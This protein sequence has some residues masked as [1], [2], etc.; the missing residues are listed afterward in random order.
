MRIPYTHLQDGLRASCVQDSR[1]GDLH[2]VCFCVRTR[3]LAHLH[4]G[5][6][7]MLAGNYRD[8]TMYMQVVRVSP[9]QPIPAA[10]C[11]HRHNGHACRPKERDTCVPF[12]VH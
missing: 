5:E 12:A 3:M 9:P 1:L 8:A 2:M 6:L 11:A 7:A 10:A 4:A